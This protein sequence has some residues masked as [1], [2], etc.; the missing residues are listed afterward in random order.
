MAIGSKFLAATATPAAASTISQRVALAKGGTDT[1]THTYDTSGDLTST[2][3][4]DGRPRTV[5]FTNDTSGQ[6]IDRDEEDTSST[7][8]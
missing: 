3:I 4:N 1:T 8:K 6:I 2:Y 7:N 5:T